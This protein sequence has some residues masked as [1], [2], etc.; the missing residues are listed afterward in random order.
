LAG[1]QLGSR[2][3]AAPRTQATPTPSTKL[4]TTA[5]ASSTSANHS[6]PER[7]RRTE[8]LLTAAAGVVHTAGRRTGS[9]AL[10][11]KLAS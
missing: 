2:N 3:N 11:F 1:H 9:I 8:G 10:A 4:N 7:A 5:S 6:P